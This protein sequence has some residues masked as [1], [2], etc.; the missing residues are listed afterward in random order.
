MKFLQCKNCQ[1]QIDLF[2]NIGIEKCCKNEN[3]DYLGGIPFKQEYGVKAEEG[4]FFNDDLFDS[5]CQK[6]IKNH[7]ISNFDNPS[8][9]FEHSF[10]YLNKE[11][12]KK[13]YWISRP[14][15]KFSLV[16]KN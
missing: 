10:I 4:K 2:E 3:I 5:I 8:T 14:V 9:I 13:K 11:L 12:Y 1:C 6:I 7:K 16:I 15:N